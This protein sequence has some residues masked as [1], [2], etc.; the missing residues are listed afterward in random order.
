MARVSFESH[1]EIK[2]G[3][4][5]LEVLDDAPF[6]IKTPCKKGKCGKCKCQV[7]GDVNPP[8]ANEKK[9]LSEKDLASGYRLACEVIVVGEAH[10]MKVDKKKNKADSKIP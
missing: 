4:P 3:T 1:F 10:V 8:T 5:L 6:K 9:H 2:T 7:S